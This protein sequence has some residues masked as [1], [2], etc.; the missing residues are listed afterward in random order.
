MSNIILNQILINEEY[1]KAYSPIPTNYNWEDIRP[2][3]G[4]AEDIWVVD[5]LGVPLYNEL[6]EQVS[7]NQLSGNN[8][9]LLLRLYP[10]LSLAVV[11]E[12]LPFLAH[13]ISEKGITNGKSDNSEPIS[14]IELS[15]IQNHIR[16]QLE[17]LKKQF[18]KWLNEHSSCYPL[19]TPSD[20]CSNDLSDCEEFMLFNWGDRRI[21]INN[22]ARFYLRTKMKPNSP[23]RLY[24]N[25]GNLY[26]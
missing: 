25:K 19:Y 11:F 17:V 4:I 14:T 20:C 5:I 3:V 7:A 21:D 13:H 8:S 2:F 24:S 10:Y 9:T 16:T 1:L 15:N 12:S 26:I 18:K 23:I 22:W 6:L